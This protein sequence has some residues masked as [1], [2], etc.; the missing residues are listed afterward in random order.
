MTK[1]KKRSYIWVLS[2]FTALLLAQFFCTMKVNAQEPFN[3]KIAEPEYGKTL[4]FP[5][6]SDI[7]IGD[8]T[9]TDLYWQ[10]RNGG[11]NM[12]VSSGLSN[13]RFEFG[14]EYTFGFTL[15]SQIPLDALSVLINGNDQ[16]IAQ[17]AGVENTNTEYKYSFTYNFGVLTKTPISSLYLT[18]YSLPV[19][20]EN[21]ETYK[22]ALN[23]GEQNCYISTQKWVSSY[24]PDRSGPFQ[25][26]NKY[27]LEIEVRTL[28]EDKT[29]SLS[30][31]AA[32]GIH[33]AYANGGEVAHSEIT[34]N[35]WDDNL[36]VIK[37]ENIVP[38]GHTYGDWIVGED[39]TCAKAGSKTR[40]CSVCKTVDTE[41]LPLLEHTK[42][43]DNAVAATCTGAGLTEG[44]SCSVCHKVFTEQQVINA[45]GHKWNDGSITKPATSSEE[46]IKTY[47]CT[48]CG[49]EKTET[50]PKLAV[51]TPIQEAAIGTTLSVDGAKYKIVSAE[52]V[53]Y[54]APEVQTGSTVIP[55]T[56]VINDKQ[57]NVTTIAAKAFKNNKKLK[58][59]TIPEGI[60]SIGASAFQSCKNLTKVVIPASVKTIGKNAFNGCKKLKSIQIK[61]QVLTSK[62]V[63]AKAFS[64]IHAKAAVKVPKAKYKSYKSI[65]KKKGI[66]GKK[67][68][69]KK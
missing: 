18:G 1:R 67:Q 53:E 22:V 23:G 37:L 52:C 43:T 17:N 19:V 54:V 8:C 27:T 59:V 5:E 4:S 48:A 30:D 14:H 39:S 50:L 24:P 38:T 29:Y 60:V 56:V 63:G 31:L 46:G 3:I 16:K 33:I 28:E 25:E 62:S 57:Y 2:L 36:I 51:S 11:A 41:P 21:R 7:A 35:H 9:I 66:N 40:T 6:Q 34:T 10:V 49:E 45:T 68:Q 65:L 61:S 26:Q 42:K 44:I 13:Y 15:T 64:G 12:R 47:T 55:A 69:I 58:K 20:G 32:T